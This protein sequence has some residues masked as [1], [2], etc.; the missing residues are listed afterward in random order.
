MNRSTAQQEPGHVQQH[1]SSKEGSEPAL[2]RQKAMLGV[3]NNMKGCIR[4]GNLV[5]KIC[6]EEWLLKSHVHC[7]F[8]PL[9][10]TDNA[11]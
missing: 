6:Q 8:M 11:S 5:I 9:V 3:I 10:V 2:V 7:V 4:K 1:V